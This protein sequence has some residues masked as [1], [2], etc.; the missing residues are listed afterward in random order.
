MCLTTMVRAR[1][2]PQEMLQARAM[3]LRSHPQLAASPPP[4]LPQASTS[5]TSL[6]KTRRRPCWRFARKCW[7]FASGKL[8]NLVWA[9][10]RC[11]LGGAFDAHRFLASS[12]LPWLLKAFA[13]RPCTALAMK[14]S[15]RT[16][17][18]LR[19]RLRCCSRSRPRGRGLPSCAVPPSPPRQ[20]CPAACHR[21]R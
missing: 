14:L 4:P 2:F 15:R 11:S 9:G 19:R 17:T 20:K 1:I 21:P 10:Q 18:S 13:L 8:K 12:L 3:T 5:F 7:R 6:K 16:K